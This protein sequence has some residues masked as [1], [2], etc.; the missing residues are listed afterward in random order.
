MKGVLPTDRLRDSYPRLSPGGFCIVD[1][2]VLEGC[3]R[4]VDDFRAEQ[5]IVDPK[6]E[7][8]REYGRF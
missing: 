6:H 2:Y 3:R 1:D 8:S 4:A 7:R 5:E